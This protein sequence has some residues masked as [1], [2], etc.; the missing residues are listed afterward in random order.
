[1]AD[2][3][4]LLL[5]HGH[6]AAQHFLELVKKIDSGHP[7]PADL[8]ALRD[9]L[10]EH[11]DLWRVAGDL[12]HAA[13]L[14]IVNKLDAGPLVAESLNHGW[15]ATKDGLGY[16]LAPPLERLLIEQVVLCW[17]HLNIIELEYTGLMREPI[18]LASAEYWERRLSAALAQEK[19]VE[20]PDS[21]VRREAAAAQRKLDSKSTSPRGDRP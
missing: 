21:V 8:Q 4:T 17:L 18:R 5:K 16:H 9:M 15:Q 10:G 12:A 2:A 6:P 13:A 11:P 7:T 19:Y 20:D 1:M 14:N 3:R